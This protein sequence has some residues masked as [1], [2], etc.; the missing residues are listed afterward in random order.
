[1]AL[2]EHHV[3]RRRALQLLATGLM[4][5]SVCGCAT[6]P[7]AKDNKAESDALLAQ[8]MTRA[9]AFIAQS[10]E[11]RL[12]FAGM[13]LDDRSTAF[14]NDVLLAEKVALTV[15]PHAVVFKLSNPVLGQATDMPY[16]TRENVEA[17]LQAISTLARPQDKVMLVLTSHGSPDWLAL[18]AGNQPLGKLQSADLVKWLMPL[19]ERPNLLV[20]S[21][22]YSGSFIPSLRHPKGIILT[23]AAADRVSFGCDS[24]SDG[25][26]FIK[27]LFGQPDLPTLNLRDAMQRATTGVAKRE[28]EMK[29][30][31]SSS[32]RSFFGSE[33]QSWAH[34]PIGDW[35][36]PLET[37]GVGVA[38]IKRAP[39]A[40]R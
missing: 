9:H 26:Y 4:A 15:D 13:A 10:A 12:L 36:K 33:A 1:M 17:V 3:W 39:L 7:Y 23:A 19:R 40:A 21:A 16:A 27:E 28:A 11:P 5:I 18:H 14:R 31:P 37:A 35:L 8:Q 20:I 29:L 32:P 25:T 24:K 38:N 34:Q 22:C 2:A 30:S 6:S